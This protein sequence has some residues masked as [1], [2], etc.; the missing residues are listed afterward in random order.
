MTLWDRLF[1]KQEQPLLK[2]LQMNENGGEDIRATLALQN[3]TQ[4]R[5]LGEKL[6]GRELSK[7]IDIQSLNPDTGEMEMQTNKI[8]NFRPGFFNDLNS[9][10]NENYYNNF[11]VNNLNSNIG[12]Q[13]N[14]KGFA[15]RLGEGLGT[16][17]KAL[18]G[19]LGDALIGGLEGR[20]KAMERQNLRTSDALYRKALESQG[21]DTSELGGFVT[22]DLFKNYSLANYRNNNLDVKMQLG[23]L[24]DNTSRAKM[25]STMLNNGMITPQEALARMKEYG[26]SIEEL[27]ESN[28]T[29]LLPFKQNYYENAINNP[30]GWANYGLKADEEARKK[31]IQN[32]VVNYLEDLNPNKQKPTTQGGMVR[33]KAPNGKIKYI[34][35]NQVDAAI[36]AGGK[37]I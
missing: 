17:T 16:F 14:R 7:D 8:T 30:L 10:M 27:Q 9:G 26:I 22:D 25:L 4:P 12:E 6:F 13:G 19:P 2:P 3:A 31:E 5:I 21:V 35:A 36:K 1:N 29:K 37:R 34:P 23:Q 20:D 28:Q 32:I 33:V 18:T 15:Y 11:D 24:K